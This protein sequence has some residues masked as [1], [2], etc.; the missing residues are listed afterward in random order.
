MIEVTGIIKGKMCE[1]AVVS[2]KDLIEEFKLPISDQRIQF[3]L[4][5]SQIAINFAKPS[6]FGA[7]A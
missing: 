5:E 2:A 4:A 1:G 7:T 6:N 3:E